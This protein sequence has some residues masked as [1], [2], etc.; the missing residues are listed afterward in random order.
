MAA[1]SVI[2][3]G[4]GVIGCSIAY[5]LGRRGV[6][7]LVLDAASEPGQTS[8]AAAGMLA[9]LAEGITPGPALDLS[10]ASLRRHGEWANE[11]RET[12]GIDVGY[13]SA[14]ILRLAL[15]ADEAEEVRATA[16]RLS[17]LGLPATWLEGPALAEVEPLVLPAWGG[18]LSGLEAQVQPEQLLA[19]LRSAASGRGARFCVGTRAIDLLREG[20]AVRGVVAGDGSEYEAES[21]VLATGA[22]TGTLGRWCGQRWPVR[23]VRGQLVALELLPLPVRRPVFSSRGYVLPRAGLVLAGATMEEAGFDPR[24]TAAGISSILAG[25]AAIIPALAQATFRDAW[26]GLRPASPDHLPLVGRVPGWEGLFLAAGHF[27][28]GILLA[29]VTGQL[30]ADL[31][32]DGASSLP[33]DPYSPARFITASTPLHPT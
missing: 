17:E 29:P 7:C 27:R 9:P 33:L 32:C 2:V 22:W 13:A 10:L 1:P 14:G 5:E 30:I 31:V 6:R 23:P 28:N 20:D 12:T 3:V 16:A 26:A 8:R 18:L 11:L 25:A 21:V 19:A 15:N 24:V 4:A